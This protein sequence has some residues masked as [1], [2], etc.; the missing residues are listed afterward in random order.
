MNTLDEG[1]DADSPSK[2]VDFHLPRHRAATPLAFGPTAF[3]R[4]RSEWSRPA[5][6]FFALTSVPREPSPTSK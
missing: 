1:R 5:L 3:P 2:V 6:P 4:F